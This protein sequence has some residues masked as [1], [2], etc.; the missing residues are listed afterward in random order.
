MPYEKVHVTIS[1]ETIRSGG[2]SAIIEPVWWLADNRDQASYEESMSQFTEPQRF[3]Y[4]L[5]WY[6]SEVS[7][8]GHHQFYY[9]SNGNVWKDACY[10][11]A[12]IGVKKGASIIFAT[13]DRI[14]EEPAFDRGT[15][16]SQLD[17][18]NGNFKDLD[19]RFYELKKSTDLD[20]I[21]IDYIQSNCEAFYW[22]G[23]FV[24]FILPAPNR[25]PFSA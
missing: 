7:N 3:V 4:A 6:C 15:R 5:R 10:G 17:Q 20:Q 21:I 1:D 25:K 18:M 11:F 8:G 16:Q 2:I 14:G 9:N 22:S 13:V 19:D 12:A 23:N 24:R